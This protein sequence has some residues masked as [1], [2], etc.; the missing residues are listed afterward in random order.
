MEMKSTRGSANQQCFVHCGNELEKEFLQVLSI[1]VLITHTPSSNYII[2]E[3]KQVLK[4]CYWI[5]KSKMSQ[6]VRK[7]NFPNEKRLKTLHSLK[8][9]RARGDITLF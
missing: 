3:K 2:S 7:R 6:T 9:K 8:K 5:V 1:S 4:F